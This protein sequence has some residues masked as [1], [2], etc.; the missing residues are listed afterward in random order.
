M[1]RFERRISEEQ[2]QAARER[3]AAGA[4]LRS[5]A[6]EIPCAPST[7]SVR[8]KKA[9]AAEAAAGERAPIGEE[10][11]AAA[12]HAEYVRE[13]KRI[14]LG[15][16]PSASA[17]DRLSAIKE[18]LKLEPAASQPAAVGAVFHVYPDGRPVIDAGEVLLREDEG[19]GVSES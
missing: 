12:G 5:A 15:Y 11:L 4:T 16:D 1:A 17:R 6:A 10:E 3:I 7:L 8:I 13:L 19:T 2:V 18:L 14:A 9:E